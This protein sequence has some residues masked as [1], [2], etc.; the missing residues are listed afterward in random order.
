MVGSS[1][2][3][4]G[5]RRIALSSPRP[6]GLIPAHAGKTPRRRRG[7]WTSGGSS[8]L[9]RGKHTRTLGRR[10]RRGLIPA[11][12][13]KTGKDN[14]FAYVQ[15]A[16]PRSRGEND[17][18]QKFADTLKGSSPLTR[19][20]RACMPPGTVRQGLIP[21]HAGKTTGITGFAGWSGAHPRSRGENRAQAGQDKTTSGSSPL[22]RGKHPVGGAGRGGLRLIPAHAGKTTLWRR[23]QRRTGAHPRSRGENRIVVIALSLT[24]GSSPLTRGKRP[25]A[26]IPHANRGLIPAHAGKTSATRSHQ[27]TPRAHP[28]SRGE[29]TS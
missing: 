7:A 13:G 15:G 12:A 3:T 24:A 29:N 14:V 8:P 16:H 23:L 17:A 20:K 2:L 10:V 28:R 26:P 11:H 19:G 21:A 6:S 4:R 22:T 27:S 9:T 5:K 18:T 1:P 25:A